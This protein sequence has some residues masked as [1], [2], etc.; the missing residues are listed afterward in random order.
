MLHTSI[1]AYANRNGTLTR[2]VASFPLLFTTS[3]NA[4]CSKFGKVQ[5]TLW[6][7]KVARWTRDRWSKIKKSPTVSNG[8]GASS[9]EIWTANLAQLLTVGTLTNSRSFIFGDSNWKFCEV[10]YRIGPPKTRHS[11]A[12]IYD[13]GFLSFLMLYFLVKKIKTCWV[14]NTVFANWGKYEVS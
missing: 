3:G 6:I 7:F 2:L 1:S 4:V 8:I 13:L 11:D 10:G 12:D 14:Y 9:F 5:E